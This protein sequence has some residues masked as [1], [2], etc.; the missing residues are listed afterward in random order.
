MLGEV[1][2]DRF[3]IAVAGTHGKTTTT[4]MIGKLLEDAGL[5]PLVF[6]GGNTPLFHGSTYRPGKG[7]YAVVEADEYDRSFLTLKPDIAIITNID[8]DHL[9]IYKDLSEIKQTFLKF[10]S[11]VKDNGK[12]IYYGD[13]TNINDFIGNSDFKKMS[14]GFGEQNYLKIKKF[15]VENGKISYSVMNSVASFDNII[16]NMVGRHNVLNSAACFA[17]SKSLGIKFEVFKNSIGDFKTVDRRLQLRYNQNDITV[18]D[19]YAHHPKEIASSLSGLKEFY[20]SRRLVTVFQPHLF[21]RTRDLYM[22]F[23][24]E[25]TIADEVVLLEIYPAREMPI[26]GVTS[27]LI[28]DELKKNKIRAI[29]IKDKEKVTEHLMSITGNGDIIVFQG[30]GDITNICTNFINSLEAKTG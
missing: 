29:Y 25:L 30:A 7:K 23:A 22:D 10:C 8:E 17:V 2:N 15:S 26:E 4:A 16:L 27:S 24:K 13:D 12:I 14:Y 19:D 20:G 6:V 3:L 5:D 18:Y 28:F 11:L 9:D 21:S 1:V